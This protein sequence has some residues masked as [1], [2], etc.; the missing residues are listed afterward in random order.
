MSWIRT[1]DE[2]EA[3]GELKDIY[4]QVVQ[5]RGKLSNIMMVQSLNTGAMAAH[6]DLYLAL[7]F[8][9]SGLSREER[10][11]IAVLVSVLNDCAYC[12]HHH[13]EA[14]NHYW[15]DGEKIGRF[16]A[17]YRALELSG[18]ERAMLEYA[19]K[20]TTGPESLSQEDIDPLRTTGFADDEILNIN[21]ITSYFNFV[22][23]IALG[24]GVEHS[25]E[26]ARGYKV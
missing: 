10:E 24:L 13:A 26:E 8:G 22:N 18:R 9:P 19:E 15:K 3:A 11:M 25:E 2:D 17:D 1:I 20:L 5:Q 21:L 12:Q 6:Q 14:L 4:S 7:M 23:R 16:I